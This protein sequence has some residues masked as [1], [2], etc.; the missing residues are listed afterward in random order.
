MECTRVE[1][2]VLGVEWGVYSVECGVWSVECSVLS[3][4][5]GLNKHQSEHFMRDFLQHIQQRKVSQLPPQARRSQR[6]QT[7]HCW[8]AK[9]SISCETSSNF[10]TLTHS[11]TKGFAASSTGTAKPETPDNKDIVGAPKR[12]F[13]ARHPLILTHCNSKIDVFLRDFTRS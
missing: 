9:T 4:D 10:D 2:K 11:A 7:R 8:S 1:C 5:C 12:A 13:H 3:L 6:L